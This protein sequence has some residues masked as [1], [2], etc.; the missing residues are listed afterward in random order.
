MYTL[1]NSIAAQFKE[2]ERDEYQKAAADFRIPYWDWSMYA[3]AGQSHFPDV[4]WSP[5]ISQY[6][7]KGIQTI[8]NPLYSYRFHPLD[9]RALSISPVGLFQLNATL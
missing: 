3:P 1:A 2:D 8:S 5:R 6:G 7:P 9:S 4:F